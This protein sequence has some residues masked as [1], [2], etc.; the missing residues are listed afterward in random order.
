M[1]NDQ[2][3]NNQVDTCKRM[4][5]SAVFAGALVGIGLSFL[6]NL[7]SMAIGL[8]VISTTTE[9]MATVA[10]GGLIGLLIGTIIAAFMGGFTAGALGRPCCGMRKCGVLYGF[11]AW[12]VAL[13]LTA[14]L[15][16]NIGRYVASYSNFVTNPSTIVVVEK[17]AMMSEMANKEAS[18]KE[19]KSTA[20]TAPVSAMQNE[21]MA[22]SGMA[23]ASWLVF[24]LFFVG[25]IFSAFGGSCAA[26]CRKSCSK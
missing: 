22:A 15:T 7:L 16:T 20:A 12:C 21:H 4:S 8:S 14:I 11:L 1:M 10:I 26:H 3:C 19:V 17:P 25:A 9:G 5:W 18:K 24:A 2:Q 6:L 23:I 13:I